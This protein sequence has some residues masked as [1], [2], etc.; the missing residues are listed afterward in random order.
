[1]ILTDNDKA[2]L[3]LCIEQM[4]AEGGVHQEQIEDKLEHEPW[5]Q[6]AHFACFHRQCATL[7][8]P[9]WSMP[10]CWAGAADEALKDPEADAL[11]AEMQSLGIS[12][13]HPDP[14]SAI[15]AAKRAKA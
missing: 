13:Y 2:A 7:S 9:P 8:L 12:R 5:V 1:M 14:K 10:P 15:A 6:A 4:R 3:R 11:A